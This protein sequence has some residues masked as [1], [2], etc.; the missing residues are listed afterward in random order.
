M[1]FPKAPFVEV[2]RVWLSGWII[3]FFSR[4]FNKLCSEVSWVQ[5]QLGQGPWTLLV[6]THM[7]AETLLHT[8]HGG[9]VLHGK[10]YWETCKN[11]QCFLFFF[12]VDQFFWFIFFGSWVLSGYTF[13]PIILFATPRKTVKNVWQGF[14]LL[15]YRR[16]QGTGRM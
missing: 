4:A 16:A 8:V 14:L 2:G 3:C 15:F 7:C 6:H 12:N 1:L 11:K 9:T 5:S 13:S 10:L